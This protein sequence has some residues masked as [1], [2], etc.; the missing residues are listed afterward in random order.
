VNGT[1]VG[2]FPLIPSRW[3]SV[4]VTNNIITNNVAGWDGAGVSLQDALVV[5]LVNNTIVSNDSTASSGM[6]FNTLGAPEAS[7]P[8][9]TNQ[10]TSTTTSAPQP[11]GVVTMRN[12]SLLT[13]SM[14]FAVLC[15]AGHPTLSLNGTCRNFS[16]PLLYN[17]VIWQNRSYY[18]GVGSLG[19]DNLNQQNVVKLYTSFTSTPAPSQPQGDSAQTIGNGT[20]ITGG[21]GACTAASYWDIG[22]RGDRAPN[23]HSS[24]LTL[25]PVYS[26]LT[27]ATDY[28]AAGG[29]NLGANPTVVN[30]YCNG[31]RSPPEFGSMG[32]Q[33]PP[34][35]SDATVPNPIFN[36]TP[37]AT[38]D[39]GN[40][41]IN[42]SWGPLAGTAPVTGLPLGNYALAN[43]S[44]AIDYIP[45]LSAAGLLAPNTDYFGHARPAV[46]GTRI[47]VG[48]VEF[49][50]TSTPLPAISPVAVNLGNV[51]VGTVSAPQTLTLSNP[52]T[53][54]LA[55]IT[56]AFSA[57]FSRLAGTAGGTCTGTLAGGANCTIIIVY[58]AGAT[59]G[60]VSGTV[61]MTPATIV[62][63][64][65]ALTVTV[66]SAPTLTSIT[67]ATGVKGSSVAVTLTG[68]NFILT[69]PTTM[70]VSGSGV[71]VSNVTL[72][73]ANTITATLTISGSGTTTIGNR[74]VSVSSGGVAA[75]NTLTFAVT[76]P[77]PPTL[78]SLSPSAHTRGGAPFTLTLT[79]TNFV[80]GATVAISGGRVFV[81]GATVVNSTTITA[82]VL[83]QGNATQTARTVTVTTTGGTSGGQT[84]TVN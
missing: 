82:T 28:Q 57:G 37:A 19:S 81:F 4:N 41:W 60:T 7:A 74:T 13:A 25:A 18:I 75:T 16:V 42:I 50:G 34:G 43:G 51:L 14:P 79:G 67:P 30:Q 65:V 45:L 12:S 44:Q 64:P 80:S 5:N 21:T 2:F 38:V 24:G 54:A 83:I 55:G 53:T 31:S 36:L 10:T 77:P 69:G 76:A 62:G 71:T 63:S 56:E 33:V 84:F 1:E 48:A 3:Y 22:V 11:A 39:E 49:Q 73:D 72:V 61:T 32:Y 46:A 58:T 40:N 78:T 6:L 8:G 59:P 9:A 27:D 66:V 29:N 52:G 20:V 23:N 17:D 70:A 68:A 47:D 26:V 15:P 35:I